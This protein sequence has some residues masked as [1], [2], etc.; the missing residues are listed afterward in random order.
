MGLTWSHYPRLGKYW[1]SRESKLAVS[2]RDQSLSVYCLPLHCYMGR[3]N[4]INIKFVRLLYALVLWKPFFAMHPQD[5]TVK[6]QSGTAVVA[7]KCAAEGFPPPV[8]IW[9]RNNSTVVNDS[10]TSNGSVSTLNL[11][12]RTI[13]EEN[14]TYMCVATNAMGRSYSSEAA[15]TFA[16]IPTTKSLSTLKGNKIK[17]VPSFQEALKSVI[18]HTV[19]MINR[20]LSSQPFTR[21]IIP[22][23]L[24]KWLLGSN[25]SR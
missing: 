21:T 6:L 15:L 3:F 11:V 17:H 16:E 5:N 1:D 19:L 20:L 18:F 9:L 24:M 2:S 10:V 7:L 8:I 14:P 13:K 23:L 12:L 25:L 22:N 4:I